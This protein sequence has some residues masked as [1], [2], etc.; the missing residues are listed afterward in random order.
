MLQ[1]CNAG[2]VTQIGR[3]SFIHVTVAVIYL[4]YFTLHTF[5]TVVG[6][7]PKCTSQPSPVVEDPLLAGIIPTVVLLLANVLTGV[8]VFLTTCTYNRTVLHATPFDMCIM[9]HCCMD[10]DTYSLLP[11]TML[12]DTVIRMSLHITA[13]WDSSH[14]CSVRLLPLLQ[15]ETPP[16]IA[17]WDSSHYCSVRLL[18]LMQCETPPINAVWDSSH[19]CSVRLL[20]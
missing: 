16:I 19:Y 18:P 10:L 9:C 11:Y 8:V 4:M 17:V 6:I 13:V 14:Y 5:H 1:G 15:C 7:C 3:C 2:Y 20:S 12:S